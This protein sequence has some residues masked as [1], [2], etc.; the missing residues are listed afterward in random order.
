MIQRIVIIGAGAVGASIGALLHLAEI[1]VFLVARGAHLQALQA[2]G[3]TLRTPGETRV[4]KLAVG[5]RPEW[6]AGDIALLCVNSQDTAAALRFIPSHVAVV[7]AQNGVANEAMA[8]QSHPTIAMLVWILAVHLEP[9]S[10]SL[11][12]T[13]SPGILDVGSISSD[14]GHVAELAELLSVAGFDSQCRVDIM[15]WKRAKL[16]SNLPG[17]LQISSA[18]ADAALIDALIAE[19]QAVFKKAELPYTDLEIFATRMLGAGHAAID[20]VERPG[21][22]LWQ[23]KARGTT[24]EVEHLNGYIVQLGAQLGVPTPIN[25]RLLANL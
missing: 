16:V 11:Y 18:H 23:S 7:C 2:K 4:L 6:R 12:A 17:I 25:S 14:A 15:S 1:P 22:S 13:G 21:G 20:G 3:L 9:G 5:E 8:A 10:V 19:G 24:S